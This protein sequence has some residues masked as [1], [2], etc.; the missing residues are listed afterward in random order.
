MRD[1]PGVRP[2]AAA[3]PVLFLFWALAIR[4]W[5]GHAAAAGAL[6]V[7]LGCATL[8]FGMPARLALLSAA[9]GAAF[10]LW[11]VAGILAG[12]V[13]L[14]EL[15]VA[16]G[17]L[18]VVRSAL[19]AVSA[20]RRIQALVVAC[21]LG[22]LLEGA[23]G[24][25]T[26][27]AI[28]G[29]LLAALGFPPVLAATVALVGNSAG[30]GFGAIGIQME[31]AGHL[32]GI[33][34]A[35]VSAAAG[36]IVPAVALAT[37]FLLVSLVAGARR[38][39]EAWPAALAAGLAFAGAQALVTATLGAPL[40]DVASAVASLAAILA[41]LRVWR[42][43]VP[44]RFPDDPPA[45]APAALPARRVL[46]AFT[47]FALLAVTVATWSLRPV[48]ALLEAGTVVVPVP[49]LH[50]AAFGGGPPLEA[51]VRLDL[52][53]ASGT[54]VLAALALSVPALGATRRDVGAV[55]RRGVPALARPVL[56]VSTVLAFAFLMK[57]SG[58]AAA[59][60]AV[61]ASAGGAYPAVSPLVGAVGVLLTGAI[62]SSNALFVPL[63]QVTAAQVGMSPL[64]AIAA[65]TAGGVC[66]Q[67]IAPQTLAVASAGVPGIAGR[68][69][70]VLARTAGRALA[71]L[72]G[73]CALTA[74]LAGPLAP[75]LPAPPVGEAAALPSTGGGGALLAAGFAL[76]AALALLARRAGSGAE[77]RE[78]G[79]PPDGPAGMPS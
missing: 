67:M 34:P 25:G 9:Q 44:F 1:P 50:G 51:L 36:R 46:R 75:L 38:G 71:L 48:R 24:F 37:P 14:Y 39:L 66:T 10:G 64:L 12:A 72:A 20:D 35:T 74:L 78:P 18:D 43:R 5:R 32:S 55:L 15:V 6:A 79:A 3:A 68:E 29:A 60:G 40:A 2:L 57:A 77:H 49:G 63:Q 69:G 47:P 58:M 42:P 52:L 8:A 7:A 19:G 73:T 4:R 26:P 11:P 41:L 45:P 76:A 16:T 27:V 61:L 65:N 22:A 59:L 13:L 21:G 70:E 17:E 30:V 54:A 28:G 53:A 33:A 62:S 31:V 23:A 56:T